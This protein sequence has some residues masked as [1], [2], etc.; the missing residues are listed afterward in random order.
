MNRTT[1]HLAAALALALSGPLACQPAPGE[2]TAFTTVQPSTS[3]PAS[4][5]DDS[6]SSPS[7]SGAGTSAST[8]SSTTVVSTSAADTGASASTTL[9]L[10]VGTDK[11]VGDLK[12][13][14]CKGKIDFLFVLSRAP[15]MEA[16]QAKLIAAFPHFIETI[17][18]KFADFD[19]HIMVVDGD[20]EWGSSVCT[21]DCPVLDCK[22]G[23]P[24]C[25]LAIPP[26]TI[27]DPC[28][29]APNYPCSYLDD[30]TVCDET[31]GAG[32]VIAA[33]T[34]ASNKICPIAGGRRYLTKDQPNLVSTFSCAAQLGTSGWGLLG[35]ALT[36]AMQP[37]LNAPGGCNAGFLRPDALLMVTF[38]GGYDYDSKGAPE[39]WAAA[40]LAAKN[41]DPSA[42]VMLDI[43]DPECLQPWDRICN[44]VKLFPYHLIKDTAKD[45]YVAA[46][47]EATDL[48]EVA[49]ADFI[50]G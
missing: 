26:N 5:G 11:D 20:P 9:V 32:N 45:D 25:P 41:G 46:F 34:N 16:R 30:V 13:P 10:D 21:N 29:S 12:P 42:V 40:V 3:S 18:A 22:V 14:G 49:C 4:T 31:I 28:C 24:C 39:D 2:T 35:E 23:Q 8:S 50:P 19:F 47:D 43:L 48:V 15:Q 33:G 17:Q 37:V 6:T 1:T 36:A 7:T 38:I 27:G 44:L